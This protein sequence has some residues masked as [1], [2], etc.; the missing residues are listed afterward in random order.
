MTNSHDTYIGNLIRER[1]FFWKQAE[2]RSQLDITT[3]LSYKAWPSGR[4]WG[5]AAW[6]DL[7]WKFLGS[8]QP[9]GRVCT[10]GSRLA[11]KGKGISLYSQF[12]HM[13]SFSPWERRLI[14]RRVNENSLSGQWEHRQCWPA[15]WC[16]GAVLQNQHSWMPGLSPYLGQHQSTG[17]VCSGAGWWWHTKNTWS[18]LLPMAAAW[19]YLA[20]GLI[21]GSNTTWL[22]PH[23]SLS[24]ESIGTPVTWLLPSP[25]SHVAGLLWT[26][27]RYQGQHFW[28][29]VF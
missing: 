11:W 4:V 14:K 24:P 23:L 17:Q 26:Q 19:F 8:N 2:Q 13:A 28:M 9:K 10:S 18:G 15:A 6:S 27:I 1:I 16:P 5:W 21:S 29:S 22:I 7:E 12:S 25:S 20:T 3:V